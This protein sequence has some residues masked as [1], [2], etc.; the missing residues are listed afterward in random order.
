MARGSILIRGL[1]LYKTYKQIG[2]TMNLNH[3]FKSLISNCRS[4]SL[5]IKD[6]N[7]KSDQGKRIIRYYKV[8]VTPLAT[9]LH[10]VLGNG[11]QVMIHCQIYE[12]A[13]NYHEDVSHPMEFL[14]ICDYKTDQKLNF[15]LR[16]I[17]DYIESYYQF[18]EGERSQEYRTVVL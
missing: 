13:G 14:K 2:K 7:A 11:V 9:D 18:E 5:V 16:N 6:K 12:K 15:I 1:I 4:I 17:G 8:F 10:P 3:Y